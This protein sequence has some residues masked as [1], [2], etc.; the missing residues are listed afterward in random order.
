MQAIL[1]ATH[2]PAYPAEVV[3]VV[4]DR[5]GAYALERAKQAAVPAYVVPWRQDPQEFGRRLADVL[6]R[7]GAEWV[8][9]AG[10]LRILDPEFVD[11]YRGRIL[12]IHPALLPAFGGR[13]MYGE[14]VHRAVLEAGVRESG[15]TV[16]FVTAEVDAGPV[17]AQARVPVYPGDTVESL[18]AR[19]AEQEHRLYPDAIRK[20]VTGRVRFEDLVAKSGR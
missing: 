13:G 20:V 14:R 18:A 8:C 19:V 11:R 2:D 10:F 12:N 16:H 9:L 1:N 6:E 15:C 17:V 5:P 3:V 4:S 7:H